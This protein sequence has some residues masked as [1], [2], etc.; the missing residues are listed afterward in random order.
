M[1]SWTDKEE[2]QYDHI[3]E[4]YESRGTPHERAQEIAARTVNKERRKRG[5]TS[6]RRS[7]G[8]GNPR[9]SLGERT[10]AELENRATELHIRG[11]STMRKGELV[12]AIRRAEH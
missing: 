1:P 11:R 8:T 5:E 9:H 6:S 7:Q 3:E 2:R 12:E 10:K 4:G